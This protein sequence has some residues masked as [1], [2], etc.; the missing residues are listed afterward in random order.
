MDIIKINILE[1]ASDLAHEIVLAKFE[2]DDSV[3]FKKQEENDDDDD[4]ETLYYT[5]DAQKLFDE[6]Y[7][8]YYNLL[9]NLKQEN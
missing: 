8:H 7:D 5:E 4:D 3:I 6:W 9:W 2:D 1:A